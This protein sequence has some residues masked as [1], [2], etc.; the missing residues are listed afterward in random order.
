MTTADAARKLME[1]YPKVYFACHRR[2]VRDDARRALLSAH[3]ASILDHLDDVEPTGV[4]ELAMHMGVTPSTMSLALDRLERG[5]YVARGRDPLDG[6]KVNVRLTRDGVRIKEK[7]SV[8]E[9]EA[10]RRML[11]RLTAAQRRAAVDGLALLAA[12]AQEHMH[13][14]G[15]R[16]HWRQRGAPPA[17][18]REY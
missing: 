4:S 10:V 14:R 13:A 12:A 17:V 8:L 3:Q 11:G 16:R 18:Q 5:G 9:P 15:A 1:H 6:R 7:Q 2:H